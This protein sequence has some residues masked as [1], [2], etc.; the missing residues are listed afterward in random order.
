[1]TARCSGDIAFR[2]SDLT[3]LTSSNQLRAGCH[4]ACSGNS[5]QHGSS[6][7]SLYDWA[8][9]IGHAV[10][11]SDHRLRMLMRIEDLQM[12]RGRC[13]QIATRF[14]VCQVDVAQQ[15]SVPVLIYEDYF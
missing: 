2:R 9:L 11:A 1:M 3:T 14:S 6:H 13:L 5:S 10:P 8:P 15:V 4:V 12:V 7:V